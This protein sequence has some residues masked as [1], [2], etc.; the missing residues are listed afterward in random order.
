MYVASVR[1]AQP[2][3]ET[4][5]K[6]TPGPGGPHIRC[7]KCNW[8]PQASDRWYCICRHRWNTFDTGGVCPS[9]L[10]QWKITQCLRCGAWS[11]HS[12]WYAQ[13]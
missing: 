2:E 3:T 5:R 13:D 12:D 8:R 9:C 6:P 1:T 11:P 7:P 10:Y 4:G